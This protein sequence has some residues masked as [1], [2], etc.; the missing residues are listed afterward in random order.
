M[1]VIDVFDGDLETFERNVKEL[2]TVVQGLGTSSKITL[3]MPLFSI[4]TDFS[5]RPVLRTV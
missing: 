2:E 4:K 1:Y 5:L 3:S